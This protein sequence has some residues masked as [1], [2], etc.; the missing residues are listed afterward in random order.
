MENALVEKLLKIIEKNTEKN[1]ESATLIIGHLK[2]NAK[3]FQALTKSLDIHIAGADKDVAGLSRELEKIYAILYEVKTHFEASPF[4]KLADKQDKSDEN[5]S[6][7]F[8]KAMDQFTDINRLLIGISSKESHSEAQTP[9]SKEILENKK[10][11][12]EDTKN[13][14]DFWKGILIVGIPLLGSV[15]MNILQGLG[16]K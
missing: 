2:G 1:T 14:R 5:F 10:L 15:V 16:G 8:E 7:L 12:L 4:S 11:K 3:D 13:K 9:S 6:K